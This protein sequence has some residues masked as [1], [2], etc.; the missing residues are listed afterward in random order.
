M[1]EV[2]QYFDALI[3]SYT[4]LA[5]AVS[6]AGDRGVKVSKQLADD[7]MAGQREAIALSKQVAAEP[8]NASQNYAALVQAMLAA[9]GRAL[10]FA[11]VAIEQSAEGGA[12]ARATIDRIAAANRAVVDS[13]SALT[14]VWSKDNPLAAFWQQGMSAFGGQRSGKTGS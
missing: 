3:E 6:G 5:E 11:R 9:Q 7:V 8:A 13:A 10:S 14:Q 4:A 2:E 1:A 12:D